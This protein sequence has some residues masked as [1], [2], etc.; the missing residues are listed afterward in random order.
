[1]AC[2]DG[3][4]MKMA[5]LHRHRKALQDATSAITDDGPHLPSDGF[6]YLDPVLVCADGFV[7][8]KLPQKI[9]LAMGTAPHH[10]TKQ[11]LE[12]GGVHDDD[13]FIRCHLFLHDHHALQLSLYPLRAAF[14]LLGN[15]CMSLFA[16]R[17]LSPDF[18]REFLPLFATFLPAC[19]ALPNLSTVVR[20]VLLE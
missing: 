11:T 3:G 5:H 13:D 18:S 14:V 10:D 4:L 7:R 20:T 9:L 1:M 2:D 8:K 12:V 19:S 17:E 6:Q 15:L 16:M